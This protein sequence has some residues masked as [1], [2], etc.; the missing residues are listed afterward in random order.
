MKKKVQESL[1]GLTLKAYAELKRLALEFLRILGLTQI[2]YQ[3]KPAVRI[4][5]YGSEREELAVR[6]RVG[7]TGD[8]RFRWQKRAKP[9]PYGIWLLPD[10]IKSGYIIVVEGESDCHTLW[11]HG[12]SALGPDGHLKIPHLWPGQNPPLR[13]TAGE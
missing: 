4:P 3:G 5:Y 6:Y 2:S 8:D 12:F 9:N 13:A 10:A 11:F 7:L 1:G